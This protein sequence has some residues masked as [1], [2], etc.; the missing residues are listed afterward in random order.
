MRRVGDTAF[1][2]VDV[3]KDFDVTTDNDVLDIADIL[4]TNGYEDGVD[5]LTDWVEI[6]TSGSD[7]VVKIDITGTGTFGGGTQ[8]AT[9]EG[10]TGLT[11]EAALV[12]S[13]NLLAA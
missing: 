1:N 13:G 4:S 7:S 11:D 3:V 5:T 9:L 2:D 10:I 12:T 8:I 6:T